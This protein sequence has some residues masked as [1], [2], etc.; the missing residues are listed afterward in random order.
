MPSS[1]HYNNDKS[2]AGV[3]Q[4][5]IEPGM[6][7]VTPMSD[8]GA[9][10]NVPSANALGRGLDI[11]TANIL[12]AVREE[13]GGITVRRE[14]NAFLDLESDVHSTSMLTRLNVPYVV[15]DGTFLVVGGAAFALAN[16]FGRTTRR[17]L[18]DPHA[19][20][21]SK[22]NVSRPG[23]GGRPASSLS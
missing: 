22:H 2:A 17:P 21:I 19:P 5:A 11:G 14:R 6:Q 10:S 4:D 13:E 20:Q 12:C 3:A 1:D 7:H 9:T 18:R 16:I 23:I 15:R 8:A